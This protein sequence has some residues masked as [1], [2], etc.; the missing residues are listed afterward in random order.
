MDKRFFLA[1]VLC[2]AVVLLT[3]VLFPGQKPVARAD[4]AR[5]GL[6]RDSLAA[7]AVGTTSGATSVSPSVAAGA[8]PVGASTGVAGAGAPVAAAESAPSVPEQR[9]TVATTRSTYEFS[10]VGAAPVG[11]TLAD[12]RESHNGKE[13]ALVQLARPSVPVLRYALVVRGDTVPLDRTAFQVVSTPAAGG[14]G[15]L[16]Y[17]APAAGGTVRIAYTFAPDSYAVHVRGRV[18]GVAGPAFV[19]ATLPNGLRSAERDTLDD[20]THLA[21]AVKP[22]R[23]GATGVPF[24]KLDPG[25]RKLEPGPLTWVTSKN[26]YFLFGM[27]APVGAPP[28]SEATVTGGAKTGKRASNASIGVVIPVTNGTFGF[29]TYAGPIETRRLSAMGRGFDGANP[30]GGFFQPIVQP[31]AALVVKVMLWLHEALKLNYGW[32]L[33]IFGAAMRLVLWPLNAKS[34]R[35]S[36]KMQRVQP[37][38]Q[39]VQEKYKADPPRMQQEMMKVYKAHDMS[40]F[41]AL[42]G[43]IPALIPMPVFFALLFVFQ[44]TI[45]FRGASFLYLSDISLKDPYYIMPLIT[46]A[47]AYLLSWIGMRGVPPNPQTKMMTYMFP[48]M[49]V[50]FCVNAAAGL[51]IYYAIGNLAA[52]PQQWMI[53]NERA[54]NAPSAPDR[55]APVQGSP[56]PSGARRA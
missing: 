39:A 41:S 10:N 26:K 55:S 32:V 11:I 40:P 54:K 1:V 16:V 27:L 4:S 6:M 23:D 45:E 49:M 47:T 9:T 17:E 30:V 5:A 34:M 35:T 52:L 28:F 44:N 13:G 8:A 51:S 19:L 21:F 38:L 43:C 15:S 50:M 24:G 33:V 20:Q 2:A 25:E 31:F 42:S 48:A 46:G 56:R 18:D 36:L 3:N 7:P 22:V 37:E 53:S 29:D 14:S 12:Y